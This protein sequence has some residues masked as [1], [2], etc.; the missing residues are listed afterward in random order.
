MAGTAGL[1]TEQL[2]FFFLGCVSCSDNDVC[3]TS[4]CY[5]FEQLCINYSCEKLEQLYLQGV[6]VDEQQLY[7]TEGIKFTKVCGSSCVYVVVC[8]FMCVCGCVPVPV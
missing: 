2:V 3:F 4:F 1:I 8:Q 6:L 7:E 5:S